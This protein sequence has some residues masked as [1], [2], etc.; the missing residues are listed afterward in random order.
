MWKLEPWKKISSSHRPLC[1]APAASAHRKCDLTLPVLIPR[2]LGEFRIRWRPFAA[3]LGVS[4]SSRIS[5][6]G[7]RE[8]TRSTPCRGK[9]LVFTLRTSRRLALSKT[10]KHGSWSM[11]GRCAGVPVTWQHVTWCSE[12]YVA[13]FP[14][15]DA[16]V[17]WNSKEFYGVCSVLAF[18]C[19]V[20]IFRTIFVTNDFSGRWSYLNPFLLLFLT[21]SLKP[22]DCWIILQLYEYTSDML[23]PF[24][25]GLEVD[26]TRT[27]HLP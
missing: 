22:T 19:V 8:F 20:M 2:L 13:K 23:C 24:P 5:R 17:L 14:A 4:E 6:H 7:D 9:S 21:R 12:A 18:G 10:R 15:S 27:N 26:L 16:A 1:W 3:L 11:E 25:L